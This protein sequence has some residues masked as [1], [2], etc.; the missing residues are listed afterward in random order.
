MNEIPER[1]GLKLWREPDWWQ[2]PY[3]L[4]DVGLLGRFFA[5]A[6]GTGFHGCDFRNVRHPQ[7]T[8]ITKETVK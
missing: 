7:A 6:F 8:P 3:C 1:G 4:K 5:A 2:C